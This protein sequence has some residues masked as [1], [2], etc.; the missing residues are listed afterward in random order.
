MAEPSPL[1]RSRQDPL[2]FPHFLSSASVSEQVTDGGTHAR[3][4]TTVRTPNT[5]QVHSHFWAVPASHAMYIH[6]V[7]SSARG[8]AFVLLR[9]PR[10]HTGTQMGARAR[11]KGCPMPPSGPV[12]RNTPIVGRLAAAGPLWPCSFPAPDQ[13]GP[14]ASAPPLRFCHAQELQ[15]PRLGPQDPVSPLPTPFGPRHQTQRKG[16]F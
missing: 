14:R 9:G 7:A 4:H 8:P 11:G 16:F 6:L 13:L 15:M 1:Q 12:A 2:C 3:T 5:A 10:A